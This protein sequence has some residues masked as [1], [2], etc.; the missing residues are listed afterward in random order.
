MLKVFRDNLK[1]LSWI[2]W[3]VIAVFILFVF[4][5]F[6]GRVPGAGGAALTDAAA[7]VGKYKVTYSEFENTYR[8][9]EDFY[10]QAYGDQFDREL[11]E[12]MG[13][14]LQV[15]DSLIADKIL[16]AEADRMGLSVTDDEVATA[17]GEM[18]SFKLPGG[19]FVGEERYKQI[20]RSNRLTV[21]KFEESVRN[22]L[23]NQKVRSVLSDNLYIAEQEVI[24]SYREQVETASIRYLRLPVDSLAGEVEVTDAELAEYFSTHA[25]EFEF[26]ERRVVDYL[27]LNPDELRSTVEVSDEDVRIYYEENSD[28]F[29]QEEQVRARHILLSLSDE[30]S[31]EEAESILADARAR[32]EA[33]EEF[34]V[35][36]AEISEDPGSKDRGGDLGFFGRGQMIPEF[37]QAA[38]AAEPGDLVGPI[39]T[40][41]GLHLIQVEEK[42]PAGVRKLDEV[43]EQIRARLT[44]ERSE[45]AASERIQQLAEK[46]RTENMSDSE[47]LS[48]LAE[49][50]TGVTF[51]TSPAFSQEDNVP[52]IGRA[53]TFS[54]EAFGLEEGEI[55]DPFQ[56]T[57]GWVILRLSEIQEP[58]IPALEEVRDQVESALRDERLFELGQEKMADVK[59][60]I[61]SGSSLEE[62]G[63][64]LNLTVSESNDFRRG[65]TIQGLGSSPR[66]VDLA[67][68]SE[69]GAVEG[70]L[71]QNR[72][73]VVFEVTARTH[74]D[75]TEFEKNRDE[76][77]ETL[78]AEKVN[79]IMTSLINQRREEMGVRYDPQLLENFNL[80]ALS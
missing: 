23:L 40:S 27:L 29:T 67:L 9:M 35:V 56:V 55:S 6:S 22:D 80:A 42:R 53:T 66:I 77:K 65:G 38:F 36:A 32:I 4:G 70:P 51:H 68:D 37:E 75:P 20:L 14:P 17:I 5:D 45:E 71:V 8:R 30:R 43:A 41:F 44:T 1:Y 74:Y 62:A 12:R 26:P 61:A 24:D 50:E 18:S 73:L 76:A 79:Q 21:E 78:R 48:S 15:I 19:G 11:A 47:A 69:V 25:E 59:S 72:D 52:G 33:G 60:A 16:L 34:A 46:I 31:R 13:L 54:V 2:L 10:R 63:A 57:R 39:E 7:T 58:R 64:T 49:T 28:E 3:L